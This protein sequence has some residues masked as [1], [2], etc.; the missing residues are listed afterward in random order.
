M[1]QNQFEL[2]TTELINF[3][4]APRDGRLFTLDDM[5]FELSHGMDSQASWVDLVA[6]VITL[7]EEDGVEA[8]SMALAMNFSL[9]RET[10]TP[11]WFALSHNN[12]P[13]IVLVQ[14]YYGDNLRGQDV[15]AHVKTLKAHCQELRQSIDQMVNE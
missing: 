9:L 2:L 8:M 12:G 10:S 1:N 13:S 5:S 15:I 6:D 14:R 3:C 11:A 4:G 7:S